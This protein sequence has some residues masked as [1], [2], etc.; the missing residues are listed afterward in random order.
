VSEE[1]SELLDVRG[2]VAFLRCWLGL[3][4][5]LFFLLK[6]CKDLAVSL[7]EIDGWSPLAPKKKLIFCKNYTDAYR[8]LVETY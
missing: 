5:R 7:M 4:L 1:R 6:L 2:C 3:V 8:G